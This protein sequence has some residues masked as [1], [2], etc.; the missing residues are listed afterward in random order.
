MPSLTSAMRWRS[1]G[2]GRGMPTSPSV[3]IKPPPTPKKTD[4]QA[5]LL[6][7][8]FNRAQVGRD[9]AAETAE[10]L[11]VDDVEVQ[12]AGHPH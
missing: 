6:A 5:Q 10:E 3:P 8:A 12:P 11:E 2:S 1:T 4:G 9:L 7:K